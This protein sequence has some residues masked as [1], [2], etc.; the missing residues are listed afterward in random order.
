MRMRHT[1]QY[2]RHKTHCI[3]LCLLAFFAATVV[4]PSWAQ[5]RQQP[6]AAREGARAKHVGRITPQIPSAN[7]YQKNK[8]FLENADILSADENVS[9]D[10]QVLKGN[11]RFRQGDMYMFCDSAYFYDKTS[12]LD[13]FGNVRMT[14]ADT[15]FVYDGSSINDPVL[16]VLNNCTADSITATSLSVAATVYNTSGCLTIRF[17]TDGQDEGAGFAINTDCVRPCQRINVL[18]DE[19]ASNKVP[20]M[21]DDGYFYLDMCPYDTIHMVVHGEFPDNDYS[22]HQSDAECT[23]HWD[24]SWETF[25]TLGGNA[26]DYQFPEGRGYDVA[27]SISDSAGCESYIPYTF[28]VRT[29]S[30]PIRDVLDFPPVCAGSE[31][32]LS[33]GYDFL[34]ALQVDTVG[35]EQITALSVC[36][37]VFLPDGMPCNNGVEQSGQLQYCSYISPVTF[38]S[39][40]PSATIQS[41][42]DILYVR[43]KLEHSWVGDIWIRLICPN[44]NYVSILK[45]YNSGATSCASVIR[46]GASSP[47]GSRVLNS[48][49]HTSPHTLLASMS[50]SITP[51]CSDMRRSISSS[52]LRGLDRKT[53]NRL[54]VP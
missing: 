2:A 18:F 24:M 42:N 19:T 23:F 39:F 31:V 3:V 13:A 35:S 6:R 22:Y 33:V 51:R 32:Q 26:I 34:S 43:V 52:L 14:Q 28:R 5:Q 40:S 10:Y 7:R 15:L 53:L 25:D 44:Q 20:H 45:K 17:K 46:C 48:C 36:D 4:V 50:S 9:A 16:L 29:S 54:C 41:A 47:R 27:I 30:N 37:T 38:T 21:E 11:V 12:S 1:P 49:L 8:V